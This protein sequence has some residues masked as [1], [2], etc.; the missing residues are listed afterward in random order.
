M[1]C[2]ISTLLFI[3]PE[4]PETKTGIKINT[5]YA[6]RLISCAIGAAIAIG[7]ALWFVDISSAP[8]LLASIGGTTVFLF[9]LTRAAAAQPRAVFGGHLGG[10]VIGVICFQAFGDAIWV[11]ILS[12]VLT[13]L[14]ML[15][16]KTVHPPAGA[17][18]LIMVHE[19]ANLFAL[20]QPVG[21][22]IIILAL[23]AVVWSRL[24]P[25]MVHYPVKW[26]DKSPPSIFWGGWNE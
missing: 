5:R 15:A 7:T 12:V 9:C 22:S 4:E 14:F 26:F 6:G 16:T 13:L 21:L 10:A 19:H 23:I 8:F 11:Y 17:N 2:C 20:W 1:V 3:M 25:G 18:P 24:I